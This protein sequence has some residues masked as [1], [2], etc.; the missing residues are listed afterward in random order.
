MDGCFDAGAADAG[1][2]GTPSGAGGATDVSMTPPSTGPVATTTSSGPT[3][4]PPRL[5]V[6]AGVPSPKPDSSG[7]KSS[8][9]CRSVGRRSSNG[10]GILIAL[11]ALLAVRARRRR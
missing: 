2:V 8:C 11:V 7:Q 9:N 10:A 5:L 1:I 3:V 6:D 4:K